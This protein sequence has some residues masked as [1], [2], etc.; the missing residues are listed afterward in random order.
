[1]RFYCLCIALATIL[2]AC[3]KKGEEIKPVDQCLMPTEVTIIP[4]SGANVVFTLIGTD[5]SSV[6]K[7][8]WTIIS[9]EKTLQIETNGKVSV[10]Q[11][12]SKSGEFKVTAVVETVCKSKT[13]LTRSEIVQIGY[14]NKIWVKDI[15]EYTDSTFTAIVESKDGGCVAVGTDSFT[16]V[17]S[18][19]ASGNILWRKNFSTGGYEQVTSIVR[20]DDGGYIMDVV[21]DKYDYGI[22]KISAEGEK[23]WE[24]NFTGGAGGW[25]DGYDRLSKVINASDGGYIL[26]GSSS[27]P[28]GVDKSEQAKSPNAGQN[29]TR[30]DYWIVKVNASGRKE[31]DRTLGGDGQDALFDAVGTADGGYILLGYSNSGKSGDKSADPNGRNY[32]M[33]KISQ[34]GTKEWDQSLENNSYGMVALP[35]GSV[36]LNTGY[37]YNTVNIKYMKISIS[38]KILWQKSVPGAGARMI[39]SNDGG[40]IMVGKLDQFNVVRFSAEGEIQNAKKIDLAGWYLDPLRGLAKSDYGGFYGIVLSGG[41]SAIAFIK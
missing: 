38:G 13:T 28:A 39:G 19:D 2:F 24:K 33:V 37:T 27:S 4:G 9:Q 16:R 3:R 12:F 32:W 18:L 14:F 35:D 22:M 25:Y 11:P 20:A 40:F 8:A 26:A 10:T 41:P 6:G 21:K 17:I 34:T 5:S 31:W 15:G 29:Y 30:T 36:I 1:M 7:V 23:L